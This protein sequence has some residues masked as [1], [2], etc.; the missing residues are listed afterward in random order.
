MESLYLKGLTEISL[1]EFNTLH[2]A[3]TRLN[4]SVPSHAQLGDALIAEKLCAVVR[5]L[6]E[7]INAIL[8]SET[9]DEERSGQSPCHANHDSRSFGEFRSTRGNTN[10]QVWTLANEHASPEPG[11]AR[12][13]AAGRR[14]AAQWRCFVRA[15]YCR[16]GCGGV[17]I[18]NELKTDIPDKPTLVHEPD[19]PY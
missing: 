18:G 8:N 1:T 5:R 2:H 7:S 6:S 11:R 12:S 14:R 13:A 16:H 9:R 10:C 3:Y 15:S 19:N 4:C 17:M